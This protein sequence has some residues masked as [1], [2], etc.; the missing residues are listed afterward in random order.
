[1]NGVIADLADSER[2][3]SITYTKAHDNGSLPIVL[4]HLGNGDDCRTARRASFSHPASLS[5]L[6]VWLDEHKQLIAHLLAKAGNYRLPSSNG[7]LDH[8]IDIGWK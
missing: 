7:D 3:T 1:M 8:R 6:P 5:L 2:R 4:G